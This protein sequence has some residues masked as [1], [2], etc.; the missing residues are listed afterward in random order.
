[1]VADKF[2]AKVADG[3]ARSTKT[4]SDLIKLKAEAE[5]IKAQLTSNA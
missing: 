1:M 5:I 4:L 2:I 3:R